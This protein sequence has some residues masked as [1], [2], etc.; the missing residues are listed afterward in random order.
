M[1]R[2][3]YD[4]VET[5]V[6]RVEV[7][8]E[9]WHLGASCWIWGTR[10]SSDGRRGGTNRRSNGG[11]VGWMGRSLV[12]L[13]FVFPTHFFDLASSQLLLLTH[14]TTPNPIPE[15]IKFLWCRVG[16]PLLDQVP[17]PLLDFEKFLIV[18]NNLSHKITVPCIFFV[19]MSI[20]S[21]CPY[22]NLF[23]NLEIN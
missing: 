2:L 21:F 8:A 19:D 5:V 4:F 14:P 15:F 1:S 3:N 12:L 9:W 16:V 11:F 20:S 7:G 6:V 17:F 22:Q 18:Q 23:R 10:S 13:A